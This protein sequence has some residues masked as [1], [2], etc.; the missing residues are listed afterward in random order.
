MAAGDRLHSQDL[1]AADD[2]MN[3]ELVT[4]AARHWC[5]T[6]PSCRWDTDCKL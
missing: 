3:C 1:S 2:Q 5:D 6:I 4:S